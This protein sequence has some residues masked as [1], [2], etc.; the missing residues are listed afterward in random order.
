LRCDSSDGARHDFQIL[1]EIRSR[2]KSVAPKEKANMA[3]TTK[4]TFS[5]PEEQDAYIDSLVASGTFASASEVVRAGLRALQERDEAVERWL[6]DEVATTFDSMRN[7]P[8][9]GLSAADVRTV[10]RARHS[11]LVSRQK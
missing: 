4:R 11:D 5:L 6:R 1:G 2:L 7:D 8:E 9:R 3:T 10:L